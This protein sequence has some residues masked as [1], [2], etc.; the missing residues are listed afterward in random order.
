MSVSHQGSVY[1]NFTVSQVKWQ[2]TDTSFLSTAIT[3]ITLWSLSKLHDLKCTKT[4]L[5]R[6]FVLVWRS[7]MTSSDLL[8]FFVT[9]LRSLKVVCYLLGS[10][11]CVQ[12]LPYVVKYT[13][14]PLFMYI[15]SICVSSKENECRTGANKIR[16]HYFQEGYVWKIPHCVDLWS[17]NISRYRTY[18]SFSLV[19]HNMISTSAVKYSE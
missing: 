17:I 12:M 7:R 5:S 6:Y 14:V 9:Y 2:G 1:D 15:F 18:L 10:V 4:K 19:C 8:P 16:C 3:E 13:D 11:S